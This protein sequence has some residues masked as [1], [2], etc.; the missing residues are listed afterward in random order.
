M[1][2]RE[3]GHT[4][5]GARAQAMSGDVVDA[6]TGHR[7]RL[8]LFT[9]FLVLFSST[10][11]WG[12]R[13][14]IDS[15][16]SAATAW[17]LAQNGT[18]DFAE[19]GMEDIY[20]GVE[21]EDGSVYTNR[22]PGNWLPAVPA[23]LIAPGIDGDVG[24][25]NEVPIW[26]SSLTAAALVAAA[27]VVLNE[28][29]RE[30][31]APRKALAITFVAAC[32]TSV[33]TVA[34]DALWT[35]S[36]G[37]L[38]L[39]AAMLS[40]RRGR[41]WFAGAWLGYAM[42]IRPTHAFTALGIGVALAI[43]QREW[44]RLAQIGIPSGVGLAAL[45][46]YSQVLFGTWLPT[47]GYTSRRVG[48]IL[49]LDPGLT[50]AF[51][52]SDQILG[53]F[54]NPYHGVLIYSPF[55]ALCFLFLVPG[56]RRSSIWA[57]AALVGGLLYW[58]AQL[59]G[60]NYIGG[61]NFFGY[62]FPIEPLWLGTIVFAHAWFVAVQRGWGRIIGIVLL[63]VSLTINTLGAVLFGYR[64]EPLQ[65]QHQSDREVGTVTETASP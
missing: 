25:R 15:I 9:F 19:I 11:S 27:A 38:V 58:A 21:V 48:S 39:A 23:Y 32:G 47:A 1:R 59:R 51:T 63:T 37:V 5:I 26:P 57:R 22:F 28:L 20:W 30:D 2:G 53:T 36:S 16:S 7:R 12:L 10:I 31:F 33:W 44:R 14:N 60:N 41:Y 54:F 35:H 46:V 62:R 13:V 40:M 50:G 61:Y 4:R 29:L 6:M 42:T 3:V 24:E 55:L 52:W 56:W 65:P 49:G 64:F 8:I 43:G 45:S 17:N 18:L 34:A